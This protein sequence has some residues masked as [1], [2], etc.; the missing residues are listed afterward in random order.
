M[1]LPEKNIA[2]RRALHH[3]L[4]TAQN[5][6]NWRLSGRRF[7]GALCAGLMLCFP[8][9]PLMLWYGLSAPEMLTITG[10][11]IAAFVAVVLQRGPW[12]NGVDAAVYL[13]T[14]FNRPGLFITAAEALAHGTMDE[15]QSVSNIEII[16][17]A[18][19]VCHAQRVRNANATRL[20][21]AFPRI[22][23]LNGLLLLG[24]LITV[25]V[26]QA[27]M[28]PA[29]H[30]NSAK[31]P[32]AAEIAATLQNAKVSG[33][34]SVTDRN[35]RLKTA[36]QP[37]TKQYPRNSSGES[38]SELS[39]QRHAIEVIEKLQASVKQLLMKPASSADII[40]GKEA[41]IRQDFNGATG[42]QSAR[43]LADQM[44]SAAALPGLGKKVR[45]MLL[46]AAAGIHSSSRGNF[47]PQLRRINQQ[48]EAYI[49]SAMAN[50]VAERPQ[51]GEPAETNGSGKQQVIEKNGA[52]GGG[53]LT[54]ITDHSG[55][56]VVTDIPGK[57]SI[58]HSAPP[59]WEYGNR[60]QVGEIPPKYRKAV[61]RYFSNDP[62]Y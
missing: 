51:L 15:E 6:I 39:A 4:Q 58:L 36:E 5:D 25:V 26:G 35:A 53:N 7:A 30:R 62:V 38:R 1:D 45:S 49:A 22:W 61:R 19:N 3:A 55:S 42:K 18:A 44:V 28:E 34:P 59:R 41:E 14:Q 24:L 27:I 37:A 32:V 16:I 56:G 57:Q 23:A 12:A 11:I 60:V 54:D 29:S 2:A 9:L 33:V 46:A 43:K 20:P 21:S 13:E 40:R 52:G 48:L 8:V 47:A 50:K 10:L 17:A 31:V